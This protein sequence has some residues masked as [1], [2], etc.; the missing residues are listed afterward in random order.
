MLKIFL[1]ISPLL[2]ALSLEP[3]QTLRHNPDIS[4]LQLG[5]TEL[6]V[7]SYAGDMLFS[8]TNTVSHYPISFMNLIGLELS[9]KLTFQNLRQWG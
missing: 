3:F 2:L 7:S 4:G 8:L 9:P 5:P 6:K 1:Y